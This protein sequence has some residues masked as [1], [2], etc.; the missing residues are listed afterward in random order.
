MKLKRNFFLRLFFKNSEINKIK[1]VDKMHAKNILGQK[2]LKQYITNFRIK[3]YFLFF[4]LTIIVV[5]GTY[6]LNKYKIFFSSD[7]FSNLGFFA[8]RLLPV[9]FLL[10]IFLELFVIYNKIF[11]IDGT[12]FNKQIKK[13]FLL[14]LFYL[15]IIFLST[16][17]IYV[18]SKEKSFIKTDIMIFLLAFVYILKSILDLL[19]YARMYLKSK[20]L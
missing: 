13:C 2:K 20:I 17:A 5:G 9:I 3:S 14:S 18:F 12:L 1:K 4:L 19:S 11:D 7:E 6:F 16:I 15:C 10:L 8:F